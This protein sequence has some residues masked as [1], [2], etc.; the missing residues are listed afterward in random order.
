MPYQVYYACWKTELT[1][2]TPP[3][4]LADRPT[5]ERDTLSKMTEN[6]NKDR[7]EK[8]A[9]KAGAKAY[10]DAETKL[11]TELT[12]EPNKTPSPG[13]IMVKLNELTSKAAFEADR[14]NKVI[15]FLG[16]AIGGAQKAMD[17]LDNGRK[18]DTGH[19]NRVEW[20]QSAIKS[21]KAKTHVKSV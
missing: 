19:E 11:W 10:K 4:P 2:T 18:K 21:L 1:A 8:I 15:D 3:P 13:A 17:N 5:E 16:E 9:R 12:G 6:H 14:N 20:Y 7:P